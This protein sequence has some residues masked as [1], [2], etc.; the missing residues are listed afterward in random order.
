M[1]SS[2]R[3]T[4]FDVFVKTT[5]EFKKLDE[6]DDADEIIKMKKDAFEV[7]STIVFMRGLLKITLV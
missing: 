5:E 6:V 1:K 2:I 7:W 3:Q 4:F